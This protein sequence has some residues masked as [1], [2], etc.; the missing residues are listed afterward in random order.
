LLASAVLFA[1][2]TARACTCFRP[3]LEG[4]VEGSS[5]I[6]IAKMQSAVKFQAGEKLLDIDEKI[7][8]TRF[9]VEKVFKGKFKVGQELN[10]EQGVCCNCVLAFD[11]NFIGQEFLF[12]LDAKPNEQNLWTAY[13]CS[14]SN[15]LKG[16]AADLMYLE[17][18]SKVRGKTRLAGRLVQEDEPAIE[19]EKRT[20]NRLAGRTVLISGGK[21]NIKLKTDANGV[22]EIYDLLP[23]KYTVTPEKIRGYRFNDDGKESA[24]V[25]IEAESLTEQDFEFTIDNSISGRFFDPNGNPL[26]DVRLNLLP[27][28]GI[29]AQ[30]FSGS[31]YT[32]KNGFFKFEKIP[33]GTY[34]IVINEKGEIT[35]ESPFGTFYYPN[36]IKREEAAEITIGPGDHFK[37]FIVTAPATAEII[38]VS[39]IL[40][41]SDG[42]PV[43]GESVKFFNNVGEISQIKNYYS[44]DS[45]VSTDPNGRF[46]LRILK[47]QKGILF[48]SL[49]RYLSDEDDCP[50][51]D[52]I[53]KARGKSSGD[54]ET[55]V[56]QIEAN[57]NLNE[58]E[59]KFPFPSCKKAKKQ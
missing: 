52:E 31:D 21:K 48:G 40:L 58:V 57:D 26:K 6:V 46:G 4:A 16:A 22:Y 13:I 11:E 19:G 55:S 34:V 7:K 12:Y 17:K 10:F 44:P 53:I 37:E 56:I 14:R 8:H 49:S 15:T 18:M 42:K 20:Y 27:A 23:G 41:F 2:E 1:A 24:E 39:G 35:A 32:D 50:V 33:A 54:V 25:E 29:K 51:L 45:R 47:G 9:T 38:T 30:Y 5:N 59:L 28:K 43:S 36:K 3:S